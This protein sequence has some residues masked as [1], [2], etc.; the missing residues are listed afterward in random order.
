MEKNGDLGMRS[1]GTYERDASA[2]SAPVN[3]R[4]LRL[5]LEIQ[6]FTWL[7]TAIKEELLL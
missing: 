4:P 5:L 6:Y 7:K 2:S 1:W 3:E